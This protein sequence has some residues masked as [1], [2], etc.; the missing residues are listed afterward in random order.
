MARTALPI[1]NAVANGG[2]TP[3][4][5]AIDQANGMVISLPTGG[6]PADSSSDRLVLVVANTHTSA[7]N[8]ILHAGASNPPAF[9]K[10]IGDAT[11]SVAA[12]STGYFG[13]F[14]LAR[15]TQ[16]GSPETLNVDFGASITGTV[17]A[18]LLPRTV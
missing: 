1:V 6:I 2:V 11:Y 16:G 5:T 12:S 9:R 17:L 4:P 18:L 10:D 7:H 13:P 15:F 14:E 8:V 3:T